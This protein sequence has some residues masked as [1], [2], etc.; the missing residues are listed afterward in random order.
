MKASP[1]PFLLWFQTS[2]ISGATSIRRRK[3]TP[4]TDSEFV[5]SLMLVD[6]GAGARI[7]RRQLTVARPKEAIQSR[8]ALALPLY[9]LLP[10]LYG[11]M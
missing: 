5:T 3:S 7:A 11:T 9:V 6:S 10:S 8:A 4:S 2:V 1:A